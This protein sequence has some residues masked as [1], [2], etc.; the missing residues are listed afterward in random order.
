VELAE[1]LVQEDE[2]L[3]NSKLVLKIPDDNMEPS[4]EPIRYAGFEVWREGGIIRASQTGLDQS[5][6]TG[7]FRTEYLAKEKNKK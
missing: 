5:L 4:G 7:T 2:E 1:F 6:K 3:D